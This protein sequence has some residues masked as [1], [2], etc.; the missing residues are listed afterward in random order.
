VFE[1]DKNDGKK[2]DKDKYRIDSS[3]NPMASRERKKGGFEHQPVLSMGQD[4]QILSQLQQQGH[5]FSG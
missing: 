2:D 3:I 5:F 4:S 1:N